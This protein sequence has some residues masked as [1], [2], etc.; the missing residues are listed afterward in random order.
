MTTFVKVVKRDPHHSNPRG[1]HYA[2]YALG[3][4]GSVWFVGRSTT[5]EINDEQCRKE[6]VDLA[7]E[8]IVGDVTIVDSET[9][10]RIVAG[11]CFE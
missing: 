7:A 2:A 9:F 6:C 1:S 8:R 11:E 4:D 3:P 5:A 10:E